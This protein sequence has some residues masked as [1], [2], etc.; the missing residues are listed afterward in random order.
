MP[1]AVEGNATKALS[2]QMNHLVLPPLRM[3]GPRSEEN[4]WSPAS[5]IPI[6]EIR[7]I[8]RL[9]EGHA[10]L[11]FSFGARRIGTR[12]P[13]G[14][15]RGRQTG[16]RLQDFSSMQVLSPGRE[17]TENGVRAGLDRLRG[18]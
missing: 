2:G 16:H 8:L 14:H 12:R 4:D 15:R 1:A 9:D 3:K 10:V 7:S 13:Q 18:T 11:A 17:R 5:P 6:E